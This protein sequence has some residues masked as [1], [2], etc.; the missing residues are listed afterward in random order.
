MLPGL[1]LILL[2]ACKKDD[3]LSAL[4]L[5]GGGKIPSV[6]LTN[7]SPGQSGVDPAEE[8]WVLFN[9][10]MD[11]QKT[12][13]AFR[14]SS[15][16]GQI[17]GGFRW[18]GTRMIFTPISGLTGTSELT[19]TIGK[20]SESESGVD[21]AE[22]VTVRFYAQTDTGRPAFVQS[23]PANGATGVP[24][25]GDIVLTFSEPMDLST[26]QSGI[27]VSPAALISYIQN[28]NRSEI[29]LRPQSPLSAGL[30]S[31]HLNTALKDISGNALDQ[32]YA[33]SLTLGTDFGAPAL[34]SVTAGPVT[35]TENLDTHGVLRTDSVVLS[36]SEPMDTNS[37]ESALTLSPFVP[38]I[39]TWD[40]LSQNLT[41]QFTPSLEA[42]TRYSLTLA[43]SATDASGNAMLSSHTYP[44]Y[45]DASTRPVVL[46]VR[47]ALVLPAF[48]GRVDNAA[49]SGALSLPLADH[50]PVALAH[51]IDELPAVG[52]SDF[53]VHLH[54][55][56]DRTNMLR[57]SLVTGTSIARI[58]DPGA[59]SL[60]IYGIDLAGDTMTLKLYGTPFPGGTGTPIYRLRVSGARDSAGNTMSTDYNLYLTF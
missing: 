14:L 42:D 37:V 24:T 36:F 15:G 16:A 30:Y 39:K 22:A 41:V 28:A 18:E 45:T 9:Q 43:T 34:T 44:F 52:S 53:V 26:A 6:V 59:G 51:Q 31:I 55:Q 35:L 33:I 12:Q 13:S 29:I 2:S 5:P 17:P 27:S 11:M 10:P 50:D 56:F 46:S 7:P 25:S 60:S 49:A 57:T 3:P 19:M 32:D 54:V 20:D 21:L 1:V 23:S 38:N 40:G 58:L 47:Q 4:L 8:P 48:Q